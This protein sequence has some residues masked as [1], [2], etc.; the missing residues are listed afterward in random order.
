[1][2]PP[3]DDTYRTKRTNALSPPENMTPVYVGLGVAGVGLL[4]TVAF[5]LLR[6]AA[7]ASAD[8]NAEK[9]RAAADGRGLSRAGVCNNTN[10][11]EFTDIATGRTTNTS[12]GFVGSGGVAIYF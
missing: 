4:R 3:R 2:Q 5:A 8:D 6:A 12:G 9:I 7:Q 10:A 1:M 11:P